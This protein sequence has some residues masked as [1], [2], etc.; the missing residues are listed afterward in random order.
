MNTNKTPEVEE[1]VEKFEKLIHGYHGGETFD[2]KSNEFFYNI[3]DFKNWLRITLTTLNAKHQEELEKAV[4]A[5]NHRVINFILNALSKKRQNEV[6][7][8][9]ES[10]DIVFQ[11]DRF[12]DIVRASTITPTKTP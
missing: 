6:L 4:V 11:I 10:S 8:S 12:A 5:E 7:I 3:A 1:I 2:V 9:G